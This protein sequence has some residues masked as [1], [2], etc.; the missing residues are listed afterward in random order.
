[1]EIRDFD[2]IKKLCI[3]TFD[4]QCDTITQLPV[5]GSSRRYYRVSIDGEKGVIATVGTSAK[6][7]NAFFALSKHF[8]QQGFNVPQV[9]AVSE[10]GMVYLRSEE[11]TSELQSQR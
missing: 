2:S 11:H 5:A 8:V 3:D 4:R 10:D 6:E 9:L 7:N 1:M